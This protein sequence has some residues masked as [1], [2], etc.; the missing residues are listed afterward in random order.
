VRVAGAQ[1]TA[2]PGDVAANV[3][4]H[5]ALVG[6]AAAAG[7]RVVVFPELSLTGYELDLLAADDGLWLTRE[8]ERLAP[9]RA[10]CAAHGLH[11]I[12]GA[13]VREDGRRLL[14]AIAIDDAGSVAAVYGKLH[15]DE[16]EEQRFDA[17]AEHV[18]LDIDG[19]RCA[20]AVCADAGVP[21]HAAQAAALGA[22]AYLVG[23][24]FPRGREERLADQMS[25]RSG[26]HGMGVVLGSMVGPA[27]RYDG[28]GRSGVWG[29]DGAPVVQLGGEPR[30]VAVADL[31]PPSS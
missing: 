6:E 14:A 16:H 25:S 23:A 20:L 22:G 9:L 5:V 10:A 17:G 30:G 4:E 11:A 31:P 21:E 24:V 15:L 8:D 26:A 7:A 19:H 18:L 29:P 3:A 27:W 2:V 12:A 13:P 1:L 28:I